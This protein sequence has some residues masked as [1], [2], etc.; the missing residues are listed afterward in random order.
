MIFEI[1]STYKPQACIERC[2]DS[3][4]KLNLP[5]ENSRMTIAFDDSHL[6]VRSMLLDGIS[7][8]DYEFSYYLKYTINFDS[9]SS[10]NI[11]FDA[12]RGGHASFIDDDD[13]VCRNSLPFFC[14]TQMKRTIH[15][16]EG[17]SEYYKEYI[18]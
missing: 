12:M 14:R 7:R 5:K 16:A 9:S 11:G 17:V 10:C 18:K 6:S 13:Y 15:N 2:S 3:Y 4:A 8:N 1:M